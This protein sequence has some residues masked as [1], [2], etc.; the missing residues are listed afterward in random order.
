MSEA[1]AKLLALFR[2]QEKYNAELWTVL[3]EL[4]V[5][6]ALNGVEL[7]SF[8][9]PNRDFYYNRM[10]EVHARQD[11]IEGYLIGRDSDVR[12]LEVH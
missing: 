9:K 1:N 11:A 7:P 2:E 3:Q 10:D 6:A 8:A 12:S 5:W 4:R